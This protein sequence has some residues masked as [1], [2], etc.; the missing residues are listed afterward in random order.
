MTYWFHRR[1]GGC[2]AY[3]AAQQMRKAAA[4]QPDGTW[5]VE[6][7]DILSRI[8]KDT[9]V[10]MRDLQD[11]NNL[12]DPNMIRAGSTLNLKYTPKTYKPVPADGRHKATETDYKGL[13]GIGAIYGVSPARMEAA[14]PQL[15]GKTFRPGDIINVP[16][17]D[18]EDAKARGVAAGYAGFDPYVVSGISDEELAR[19]RLLESGGV[20]HRPGDAAKGP[21]S[22]QEAIFNEVVKAHPNRYGSVAFDDAF[23]TDENAEDLVRTWVQDYQRK[24]Q[25]KNGAPVTVYDAAKYWRAGRG[26]GELTGDDYANFVQN[27]I[28]TD[29]MAHDFNLPWPQQVDASGKP[30]PYVVPVNK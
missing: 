8:S 16:M 6:P 15:A 11:W 14:N 9:G 24:Y 17:S 21:F 5:K 12:P 25:I 4:M 3:S 29:K 27:G 20:Q 13:G 1:N 30:V 2:S 28:Y 23:F 18:Y 22:T 19:M 7:G 10:S 26:V